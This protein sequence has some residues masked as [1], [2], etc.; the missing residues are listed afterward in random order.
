MTS[1]A[2]TWGSTEA[3][4]ARPYPCDRW[5]PDADDA[6]FRAIDVA[7]PPAVVFR[8]LC[9]LRAA[10]YSYDWIDNRGQRSPREL[11]PGL[12]ELVVGQRFMTIFRLV[13]HDRDRHL[14]MVLDQP[15]GERMFGAL[16]LTYEV[17][18]TPG[19]SRLVVKLAIR[20]P[21]GPFRLLAPLLPGADLIMMRKQLR[22][23]KHL[24]EGA[25]PPA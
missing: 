2:H 5:L 19:G 23:L 6:C 17:T 24:A 9:Q 3:E 20:R 18:G 4:R 21:S 1:D 16:A 13:D 10:P 14:T 8:W 7:A 25:G 22:T 15:G 11:T 12:D